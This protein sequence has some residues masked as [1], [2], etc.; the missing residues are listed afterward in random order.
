MPEI[1]NNLQPSNYELVNSGDTGDDRIYLYDPHGN[2]VDWKDPGDIGYDAWAD[3]L[4]M[5][6]DE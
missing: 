6:D 3:A 5:L 1:T 2:K 4:G